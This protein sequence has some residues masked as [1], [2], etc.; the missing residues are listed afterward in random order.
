MER[1]S[2]RGIIRDSRRRVVVLT[3]VSQGSRT[4]DLWKEVIFL[5]PEKPLYRLRSLPSPLHVPL[6]FG[7]YIILRF[8]H[9][10]MYLLLLLY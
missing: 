5:G 3:R 8:F 6:G 4:E 2:R 1:R 10:F 9:S 7:P